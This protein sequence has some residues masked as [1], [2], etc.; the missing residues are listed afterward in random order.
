MATTI[1]RGIPDIGEICA[2]FESAFGVEICL[3]RLDA[4]AISACDWL[5]E[6]LKLDLSYSRA[7]NGSLSSVLYKQPGYA[8]PVQQY[9]AQRIKTIYPFI[10]MLKEIGDRPV[11][12]NGFEY[13]ISPVKRRQ[14]LKF[15]PPAPR[16]PEPA[17]DPAPDPMLENARRIRLDR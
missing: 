14:A 16:K 5:K 11:Y 12:F 17:P 6:R 3:E 8:I 1:R 15:D 10:V 13:K 4:D 9:A 2:I 7:Q